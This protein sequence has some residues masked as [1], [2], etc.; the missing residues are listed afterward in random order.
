MATDEECFLVSDL[1]QNLTKLKLQML[2][3]IVHSFVVSG[4]TPATTAL[5]SITGIKHGTHA[6]HL[7]G[8]AIEHGTLERGQS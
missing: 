7:E 3:L 1:S 5:S 2:P 6:K 8:S 4:Q